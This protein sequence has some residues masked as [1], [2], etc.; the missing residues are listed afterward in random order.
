[1]TFYGIFMHIANDRKN[2]DSI[3]FNLLSRAK[4]GRIMIENETLCIF[5]IEHINS[6]EK[7]R[8]NVQ[9]RRE[10]GIKSDGY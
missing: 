4:K 2:G 3:L 9:N 7:R 10:N 6:F 1:M 5:I 8:Y